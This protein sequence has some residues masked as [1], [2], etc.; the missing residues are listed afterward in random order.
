MRSS[1]TT[2]LISKF[3]P[4][5]YIFAVT[6]DE[7]IARRLRLLWG[8]CP[9]RHEQDLESVDDMV[10]ESTRLAY[11]KGL[12]GK[13]KDIVFTSGVHMIPGRTNVVGVFQVKDLVD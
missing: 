13:D 7:R 12:V 2:R 10:R 1:S 3:R 4:P 6:P 11:E 8:V 9:I 5:T